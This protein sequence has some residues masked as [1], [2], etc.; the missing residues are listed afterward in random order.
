[1]RSKLLFVS[2]IFIFLGVLDVYGQK[3][4]SSFGKNRIQYRDFEWV[5][6]ESRHFMIYS[7]GN[8]NNIGQ[9]VGLSAEKNFP[10]IKDFLQYK[11]R[12][13]LKILVFNDISDFSQSNIGDQDVFVTEAGIT[14]IEN[15]KIF[16]YFDGNHEN[17]DNQIKSG[18]A[19]LLVN[20]L[21]FGSNVKDIVQNAILLDLPYWFTN[22]VAEYVAQG[23]TSGDQSQWNTAL[24]KIDELTIEQLMEDH[25]MI[26]GKKLWQFTAEKYGR[27]SISNIIYITR[28]NRSLNS[29]FIYATGKSVDE[30]LEEMLTAENIDSISANNPIKGKNVK[31][32]RNVVISNLAHHPSNHSIAIGSNQNGKHRIQILDNNDEKT[33]TI[34]KKGFQNV[35]QSSDL[36]YPLVD[37]SPNGQYLCIINESRD[38]HYITLYDQK[39]GGKYKMMIPSIFERWTSVEFFR[40]DELLFSGISEGKSD[41]YIYDLKGKKA[42]KITSD[43]YDDSYPT[44]AAVNGQQ[45][46]YFV[47]NR[48][49]N[50]LKDWGSPQ[51]LLNENDRYSIYYYD[52]IT[53][54]DS[55][56]AISQNSFKSIKELKLLDSNTLSF[57][58]P[59]KNII[60]LFTIDLETSAT[61]VQTDFSTNITQYDS[62]NGK[63]IYLLEENA[64]S[65]ITD[66]LN[67]VNKTLYQVESEEKSVIDTLPAENETIF[68]TPFS[69]DAYLTAQSSALNN[70]LESS[71][72]E[73]K[74]LTRGYIPQFSINNFES[75]IDNDELHNAYQ[76]FADNRIVQL[77]PLSL[78]LSLDTR[79]LFED[80]RIETGFRIPIGLNGMDYFATYQNL[81]KR[82]DKT[83]S[84]FWMKRTTNYNIGLNI[85]RN[86]YINMVGE[87]T[88]KYPFNVFSSLSLKTFIREDRNIGLIVDNFSKELPVF[89]NDRIGGQLAYVYD[90]SIMRDYNAPKGHK[91]KIYTEY[92]Q[93]VA[94][95]INGEMNYTLNP[96]NNTLVLGLDAR[97]YIPVLKHSTLAGRLNTATS[98]GQEKIFYYIGDMEESLSNNVNYSIPINMNNDTYAYQSHMGQLRGFYSNI[99]NGS[100]FVTSNVEL[101]IS[102][103]KYL[104]KKPI[105]SSMIRNLQFIGFLDA[106]TAWEGS[107]PFSED[108]PINR[109]Q[110]ASEDLNGVVT[111][112]VV[113]YYR[114]PIVM[115]YGFGAR[116]TIYGYLVKAD[117]GWGLDS[118]IT[119]TPILHL[120]L[121]KDF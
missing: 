70:T 27:S 73:N 3:V 74:G 9:Y 13:K 104:T 86:K 95:R 1:M 77:V 107:N 29:G 33:T 71:Q 101:R 110:Y 34:F 111:S 25:P 98:L 68:N 12:K 97:K 18:I 84:V 19:K 15:D 20:N 63:A 40:E 21:L 112:I 121:G 56:V 45:G 52:L 72:K 60:A 115:G 57:L 75:K 91:L 6:S 76:S 44:Y 96:S 61:Y 53:K 64:F 106:G 93:R 39:T 41:I 30:I 102:P 5:E 100:S 38:K 118:G 51:K 109:L 81:K 108:N 90:N 8:G 65:I 78:K 80:H 58:A 94:S 120:S 114:N 26:T 4:N 113:N 88:F 7:Y 28:S 37:W 35:L 66:E 119:Q 50:S 2:A 82:I 105:R 10:A 89:V 79:D 36:N 54:P 116:T 85:Y 42:R 87:A 48:T 32:K 11:S 99:R 117:V 16:V 67:E 46:I 17:L 69:D 14:K 23:W 31:S 55:V 103:A 24:N 83:F 49:T 43:Y 22:S 92:H 47:S 62:K 59:E